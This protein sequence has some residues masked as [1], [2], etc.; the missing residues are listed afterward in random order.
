MGELK[1]LKSLL[2]KYPSLD[3]LDYDYIDPDLLVSL[4]EFLIQNELP[5]LRQVIAPHL[6]SFGFGDVHDIQAY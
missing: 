2:K 5:I 6:S 3:T 1:Q 4:D